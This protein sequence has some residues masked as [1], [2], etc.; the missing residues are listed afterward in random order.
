MQYFTIEE[1]CHSVT[2]RHRDIDNTPSPEV[3][4]NL[5]ALVDNILDPLR[6]AWGRPITVSS[7]Y[8]SPILNGVI[9]GAPCS[10]HITGHAADITAGDP[11]DNRRLITMIRDMKLPY[12]QLI[13]ERNARWVHVSYDPARNRRMF[14]SM[15]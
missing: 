5:T 15:Y 3:V 7:G 1:L 8:R 6:C 9:G 11:A 10:Q 2:A 13:D 12:D 4:R 14:F